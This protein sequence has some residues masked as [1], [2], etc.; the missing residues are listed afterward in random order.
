[1]VILI[2][3]I[4]RAYL[5][6]PRP[7][8]AAGELG[9]MTAMGPVKSDASKRIRVWLIVGGWLAAASLL[10][11]VA[12]GVPAWCRSISPAV[13]SARDQHVQ[14]NG[15]TLT[16]DGNMNDALFED[17]AKKLDDG[18]DR[19]TKVSVNSRG[20][21][22][23]AANKISWLL[24]GLGQHEVVVEAGNTCQSACV[25]LLLGGNTNYKVSDAGQL[26]F[27]GVWSLVGGEDCLACARVDQGW[28]WVRRN[29]T[30]I[31]SGIDWMSGTHWG[32]PTMQGW[33]N[34]L[35]TGLGDHLAA[36]SPNPFTSSR[37]YS[38]GRSDPGQRQAFL[39]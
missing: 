16:I 3:V 2:A 27:H 34:H 39:A 7:R 38:L 6:P 22:E 8:Q 18:P 5:K 23:K 19:I 31:L 33:A 12:W 13:P 17:V 28:N 37:H 9:T 26:M 32:R 35:A 14:R 30:A 21:E 24:E 1:M 4:W 10:P 25:F 15:H 36:C 29:Y 20:G 11:A